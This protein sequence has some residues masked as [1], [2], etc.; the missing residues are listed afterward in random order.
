MKAKKA[1]KRLKKAKLLLSSVL[2][3]YAKEE[4]AGAARD[5]LRAAA[6]NLDRAQA[7]IK[8]ASPAVRPTKAGEVAGITEAPAKRSPVLSA[9]TRRKLS[10]AAKKRWALAKRKG[11]GEE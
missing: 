4:S 9:E 1:V 3:Q 7:S 10:L 2:D 5:L 11:A 6:S 8:S